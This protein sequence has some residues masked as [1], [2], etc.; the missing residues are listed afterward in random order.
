MTRVPLTK[1]LFAVIDDADAELVLRYKWQA[2]RGGGG[3]WYASRSITVRPGLQR[4]QLLHQL[5]T[6]WPLTDHANGD[7]LDNQRANLRQA[8][9][10]QNTQNSRKRIGSTSAYKGVSWRTRNA[11]WVAQIYV[12][13]PTRN[14]PTRPLDLGVHADEEAAA[15]AYD[16][17]ARAAFGSYAALNFPTRDERGATPLLPGQRRPSPGS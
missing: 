2:M 1:G 9:R 7:G 3:G 17:A 16:A 8:T 5:L 11:A 14:P 13:D 4:V 6:G 15:R 10:A 12:P